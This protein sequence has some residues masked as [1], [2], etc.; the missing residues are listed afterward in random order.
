MG[1]Y[2]ELLGLFLLLTFAA[3]LYKLLASKFEVEDLIQ[4]LVISERHSC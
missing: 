1:D 4:E 2:L 3:G